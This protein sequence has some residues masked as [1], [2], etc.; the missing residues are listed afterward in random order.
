MRKQATVLVFTAIL[1]AIFLAGCGEQRPP[2][3]FTISGTVRSIWLW[4]YQWDVH[5]VVTFETDEGRLET[6]VFDTIEPLLWQGLRARVTYRR[7]THAHYLSLCPYKENMQ[8]IVFIERL[9]R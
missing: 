1:G 8:H 5:P 7:A 4:Q 9:D 2:E 3:Q 6:V